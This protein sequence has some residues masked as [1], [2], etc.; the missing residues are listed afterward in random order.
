M[1]GETISAIIEFMDRKNRPSIANLFFLVC[2][3]LEILSFLSTITPFHISVT[4]LD[5]IMWE[6]MLAEGDLLVN[7][8]FGVFILYGIICVVRRG[9][10]NAMREKRNSEIREIFAK[11]HAYSDVAELLCAIVSL[12]FIFSVF[13]Q[14][15]KAS[16][17]FISNKACIVYL[18][19]G[20]KAYDFLFQ[21]SKFKNLEIIDR[22]VN[23]YTELD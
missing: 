12:V 4:I 18:L 13:V 23:N 10:T 7:I 2:G 1:K 22:V 3:V 20:Y 19:I 15:Y 9:I 21:Y 6:K 14:V 8:T 11:V 17:L 5:E 16:D